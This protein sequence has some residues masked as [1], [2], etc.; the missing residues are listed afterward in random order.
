MEEHIPQIPRD[1]ER[2]AIE[3][4]LA[5]LRRVPP[6]VGESL[7]GDIFILKTALSHLTI[8]EVPMARTDRYKPYV[9]S[10]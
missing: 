4:Y 6:D 3:Q 8:D 1:V 2:V 10:F 5:C 7:V 9:S